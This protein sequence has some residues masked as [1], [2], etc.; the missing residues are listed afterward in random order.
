MRTG[1]HSF[2]ATLPINGSDWMVNGGCTLFTLSYPIVLR[3]K[4]H[5]T[6][7]HFTRDSKRKANTLPQVTSSWTTHYLWCFLSLPTTA[8]DAATAVQLLHHSTL[9]PTYTLHHIIRRQSIL[10]AMGT[11]S[12]VAN[13]WV[14]LRER[15]M[16]VQCGMVLSHSWRSSMTL[17]ILI[18]LQ[19]RWCIMTKCSI[20]ASTSPTASSTAATAN[21]AWHHGS[22]VKFIRD[23]LTS[24]IE[25]ADDILGHPSILLGHEEGHGD[26]FLAC[27]PCSSNSVNVYGKEVIPRECNISLR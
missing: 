2:S 4:M 25:D 6:G 20:S 1:D 18:T 13:N 24:S 17:S 9:H 16:D 5:H 19:Y 26:T 11:H 22:T 3:A 21:P 23:N 15:G 12:G 8:R 27:T 14:L 10:W 7:S